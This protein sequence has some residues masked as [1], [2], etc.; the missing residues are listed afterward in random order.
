[1]GWLRTDQDCIGLLLAWSLLLQAA[2]LS[3]SSGMQIPAAS[4]L[5][6]MCS[7]RTATTNTEIPVQTRHGADCACCVLGC[8]LSC[9]GAGAAI[10]PSLAFLLTTFAAVIHKVA[11]CPTAATA[12]DAGL[13]PQSRAPPSPLS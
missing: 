2:V 13:L 12:V 11:P 4:Q 7:T 8:H 3:F 10:V 9:A 1:M 5:A 6:L